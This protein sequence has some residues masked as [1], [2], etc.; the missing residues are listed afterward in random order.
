MPPEICLEQYCGIDYFLPSAELDTFAR[1]TFLNDL[2]DMYNEEHEHLNKAHIG[3]LWTN[4]PNVK[5]GNRI[6][7][8]CEKPFFRGNKWSKHRQIMQMQEWFG[9]IPDFVI[10]LDAQLSSE[11]SDLEFC[12][13]LDHELYHAGH[14]H[15]ENGFPMFVVGTGM[16]SFYIRPHDVEEFVGIIERYGPKGGAGDSERFIEAAKNEPLFSGEEIIIACGSCR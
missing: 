15:D 1:R 13:T 10:T 4:V 7:G 8:T 9:G 3:W 5:G 14:Q 16:P 12:A 11:M 2:S 6:V